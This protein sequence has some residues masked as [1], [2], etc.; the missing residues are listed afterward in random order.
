MDM[1]AGAIIFLGV[2]TVALLYFTVLKLS[3]E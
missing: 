3:E 2:L 1:A